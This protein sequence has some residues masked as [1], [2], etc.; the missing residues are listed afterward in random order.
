MS[1][2][3]DLQIPDTLAQLG[4]VGIALAVIVVVVWGTLKIL[5]F[6]REG[7]QAAPTTSHEV[8]LGF[9]KVG[10][11]ITSALP[12][13]QALGELKIKVEMLLTGQLQ[14]D[15]QISQILEKLNDDVLPRLIRI[16]AER[17]VEQ[18][19]AEQ[20]RPKAQRG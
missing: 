6:L 1:A 4:G 11:Q 20:Q 13:M 7:K 14:A 2:P 8:V 9:P 16:E 10:E 15:G 19:N 17:T 5:A 12:A 3:S 18:R